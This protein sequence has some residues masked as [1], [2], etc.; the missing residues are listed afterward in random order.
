MAGGGGFAG[1]GAAFLKN[2]AAADG[3]SRS[4]TT[5]SPRLPWALRAAARAA[6]DLGRKRVR[7]S[8]LQRLLSRSFSARFG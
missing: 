3:A 4:A 7:N 6:G 8:Q 5:A 2:L 1:D